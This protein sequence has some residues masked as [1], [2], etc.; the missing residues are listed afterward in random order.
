MNLLLGKLQRA[1]Y[2]HGVGDLAAALRGAR[3]HAMPSQLALAV[4]DLEQNGITLA[5]I[6]LTPDARAE[7]I[8]AARRA[9]AEGRDQYEAVYQ[10]FATTALRELRKIEALKAAVT[11]H[12]PASLEEAAAR[13]DGPPRHG[14]PPIAGLLG[15]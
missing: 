8:A 13:A 1:L 9:K 10:V 2:R 6:T 3:T 14:K 12:E 11:E 5:P 4:D 15:A 7:C